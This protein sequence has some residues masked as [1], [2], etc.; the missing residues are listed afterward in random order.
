[1]PFGTFATLCDAARRLP[2]LALFS[3]FLSFFQILGRLW[4][5]VGVSASMHLC[6]LCW[7][8]ELTTF[9]ACYVCRAVQRVSGRTFASS[10][11]MWHLRRDTIL[12]HGFSRSSLNQLFLPFLSLLESVD[13]MSRLGSFLVS[14]VSMSPVYPALEAGVDVT[15]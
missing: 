10:W 3:S 11:A 15:G 1:M 12:R 2:S 14:C 4:W 9:A 13:L 7:I 8:L 6:S 5:Q